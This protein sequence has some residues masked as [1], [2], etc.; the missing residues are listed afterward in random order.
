MKL[1]II[2]IGKAKRGPEQELIKSWT[3]RLPSFD[4]IVE[5]ESALPA[6]PKRKQDESDKIL[7]WLNRHH[8]GKS[9]LIGLDPK[10]QDL[11]SEELAVL[12]SQWRDQ[13]I[14]HCY[15]AIGGAEG[16][17]KHL[18]EQSQ[19]VISFGRATW[20]HMLCRV[21]LAE[22]IYRAEMILSGHPYHRA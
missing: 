17:D 22:Q 10:G 9:H 13:G 11:S 21:M 20:P 15:F 5:L 12:I 14:A 3:K 1:G 6:G 2:A 16:H 8:A 19:K 4:R 7:D 18:I